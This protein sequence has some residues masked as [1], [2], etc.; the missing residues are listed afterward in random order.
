MTVV[1]VTWEQSPERVS[2][3]DYTNVV[4]VRK[5]RAVVQVSLSLGSRGD[6]LRHHLCLADHCCS[7]SNVSVVVVPENLAIKPFTG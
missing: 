6:G 4:G 3:T 5:P 1:G 2:I 7:R